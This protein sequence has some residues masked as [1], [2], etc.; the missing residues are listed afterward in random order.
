MPNTKYTT[1]T[2]AKKN[3]Y[4]LCDNVV[5]Y[6][7]RVFLTKNGQPQVVILSVTEYEDYD[8]QMDVLLDGDLLGDI[9]E[10]LADLKSGNRGYKKFDPADYQ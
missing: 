8:E 7:G 3:L 1:I 4:K 2:N 6:E 9:R 10:S 5:E